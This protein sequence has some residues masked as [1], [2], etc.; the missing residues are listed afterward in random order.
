M[1]FQMYNLD[2]E[3]QEIVLKYRDKD[4]LNE[5]HKM[6]M[7]VAYGLE[8][9]WGEHLRLLRNGETDKGNYWKA[10]WNA[11]VKIM[12]KAKIKVPTKDI[13]INDEEN[14][15]KQIE[16]VARWLW[17][18]DEKRPFST[19]NAKVTLAVLTQLCDSLVWWAQRYK[20]V[21]ERNELTTR[22]E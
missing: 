21:I 13:N 6:R 3:A 14:S 8:R 10:T 2:R 4:V 9:F 18:C 16:E 19:E 20:K 11:L 22:D 17:G 15:T 1:T 12:G 7:T 5:S